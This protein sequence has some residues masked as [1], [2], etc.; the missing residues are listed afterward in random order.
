MEDPFDSKD[1]ISEILNMNCNKC[2][3]Q[4]APH[5]AIMLLAVIDLIE[6]GVIDASFFDLDDTLA[7]KFHELWN[8]YVPSTS[9]F[10]ADVCKPFYHLNHE[11]FWHLELKDGVDSSIFDCRPVYTRK[12][13]N[14][15]F[16]CAS[17]NTILFWHLLTIQEAR[18]SLRV[19]LIKTYL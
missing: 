11:P 4:V 3:G 10:M 17:L 8:K 9:I 15:H 19:L 16:D 2:R 1:Y 18:A 13:M 5:K 6:E 12:W 14:D 7:N